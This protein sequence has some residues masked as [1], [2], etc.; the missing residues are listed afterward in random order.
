[1]GK[2][3]IMEPKIVPG[4]GIEVLDDEG[5]RSLCS[6]RSFKTGESILEVRGDV[7]T[8]ASR[9]SI[10]VSSDLHIEPS[11]LP[12][13][14]EFFD[15]YLWPFLNH[16][17]EPNAMM[18]G[19]Q[20]VAIREIAEGE[21]ITFDYNTNEWDMATPFECMITGRK[22]GGYKHLNA[23]ERDQIRDFTSP[24]ILQLADQAEN[25]TVP[26]REAAK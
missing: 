3:V 17:F 7:I 25:A 9:Y 12:T 13:N 26:R 8:T 22:V 4:L 6:R 15:D 24:F 5:H 19:R 16:G 21:E 11:A 1:M 10:Q 20:L 2:G 23:Q 18:Q 14:L